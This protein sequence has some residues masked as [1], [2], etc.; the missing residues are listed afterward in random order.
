[1]D[2]RTIDAYDR[3]AST[4]L[5]RR[6]VDDPDRAAAFAAAI[7]PGG[8]RLDLGSGPGH[9]TGLLGHPV[10]ALD[11][12]AAMLHEAGSRV[13]DA[14]RVLAD[15]ERLP[16][17]PDALA[18]TWANK[19]LQH[20]PPDHLPMVLADLHRAMAVGGRLDLLVFA[21]TG[22]LRSEDDLPGRYFA[23]WS[24]ADLADVVVGAGFAIEQI[25]ERPPREPRATDDPQSRPLGSIAI[26]ASRARTLSDVVGPGMR[27]LLCGLNPS[28]YA[29]DA[30][31]GFA[32]PGNRFW[33]AMVA[34]GLAD[35]PRD[36]RHL[37]AH[38]R[39]GMTDLVKRATVSAAELTPHEYRE[40]LDRVER[41]VARLRPAAVCFVGLSGW[42]SAVDR[43]AVVGWQERHLAGDVPVYVMP[44]TSGLNAHAKPPELADHLRTAVAGAVAD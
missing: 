38:H 24:A 30:G 25:A 2:R 21:G 36:A 14:H 31:V 41:L 22:E 29:A 8:V 20:V 33:P 11:G 18:G 3:H 4:Y 10:V 7:P 35:V 15:L 13:P 28:L 27:L 1:M 26:T 16:F 19:A 34:A 43:R 9:Y 37:L 17:R 44:N 39:I 40:G 6:G 32:R 23:L 12:S 5:E 42:R